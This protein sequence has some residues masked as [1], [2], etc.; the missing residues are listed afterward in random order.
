MSVSIVNG[1]GT[2][3]VATPTTSDDAKLKKTAMQMEGIFVQR[4]F[5]AMR[6]TIP[7]DG[8]V[9]QSSAEGSP[10]IDEKMSEKV[11]EQWDNGSHSLARALYN[12]LRQRLHAADA[13]NASASAVP[14]G[15][16]A[17]STPAPARTALAG[18]EP[19]S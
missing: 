8:L 14:A 10:K 19:L 7:D 13:S 12:Q 17:A 3:L 9:A 15:P 5:A 1:P 11:P 6:D 18:T 4:L 2:P 16:F